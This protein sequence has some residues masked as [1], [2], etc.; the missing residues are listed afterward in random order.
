MRVDA[1][2]VARGVVGVLVL[3]S[4]SMGRVSPASAAEA[5][6]WGSVGVLA[7]SSRPDSELSRYR[8]DT[9][10][11]RGLGVQ[12]MVGFG[13][14]GGGLRYW[15]TYTTQS[16]GLLGVEIEPDVRL[17]SYEAI[18]QLRL[19]TLAGIQM[20]ATGSFGQ[21]RLSYEPATLTVDVGAGSLTEI[22]FR[23][24]DSWTTSAG[25][26]LRRAIVPGVGIGVQVD[27]SFFELDVLHR[28]GD[29]IVGTEEGFGHWNA[30][31]EL[32][33]LIGLF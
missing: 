1:H 20:A 9:G 8:W 26:A 16:T 25:L 23:P 19:F 6:P 32:A 12:G 18:A 30:R 24:I 3:A 13:I 27:R 4:M 22:E 5:A 28:A 7:G 14:V 33:W 31:V 17:E 11:H 15:R 29:V 2:A 21:L 10:G